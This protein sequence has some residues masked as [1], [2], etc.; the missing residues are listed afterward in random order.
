MNL[1]FKIRFDKLL[2]YKSK[3]WLLSDRFNFVGQE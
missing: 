1:N 2:R 3:Y